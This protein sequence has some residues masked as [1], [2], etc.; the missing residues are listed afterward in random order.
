MGLLCVKVVKPC[1]FLKI[2]LSDTLTSLDITGE[3]N[4]VWDVYF[5]RENRQDVL[6]QSY[7]VVPD[8]DLEEILIDPLTDKS[9]LNE[10]WILYTL[11][12]F[13]LTDI[14]SYAIHFSIRGAACGVVSELDAKDLSRTCLPTMN[15]DIRFG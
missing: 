5:G 6:I 10:T 13:N 14:R 9:Y 2:T 15:L 4:E 8:L 3:P 12:A 1:S 11:Q 7:S